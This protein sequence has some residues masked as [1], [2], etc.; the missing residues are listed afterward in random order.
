VLGFVALERPL[1]LPWVS[2][3]IDQKGTGPEEKGKPHTKKTQS[4][5]EKTEGDLRATYTQLRGFGNLRGCCV[6][7]TF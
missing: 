4:P 5:A 7:L 3:K 1:R 6:M 2:R